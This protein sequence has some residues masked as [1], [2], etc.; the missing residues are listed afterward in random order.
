MPLIAALVANALPGC[1]SSPAPAPRP[2]QPVTNHADDSKARLYPRDDDVVKLD[3]LTFEN[4]DDRARHQQ[5]RVMI[6]KQTDSPA[7]AHAQPVVLGNFI[8][9]Y[10]TL[11][12]DNLRSSH[13]VGSAFTDGFGVSWYTLDLLHYQ[14]PDV[15][16]LSFSVGTSPKGEGNYISA[17][18]AVR[19]KSILGSHCSISFARQTAEKRGPPIPIVD[20]FVPLP[21]GMIVQAP[22]QTGNILSAPEMTEMTC[23]QRFAAALQDSGKQALRELAR[24]QPVIDEVLANHQIKRVTYGEYKGDGIPPQT[25]YHDLTPDEEATVRVQ[26]E[27]KLAWYRENIETQRKALTTQLVNL[28]PDTAIWGPPPG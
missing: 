11:G 17:G 3:A 4:P 22:N 13:G 26:L 14:L 2:T 19:G 5:L 25:I 1:G 18:Y 28:M 7:W 10:W 24:L 27:G 16:G 12:D 8:G 6:R 21:E 23:E 9:E 20:A 15:F